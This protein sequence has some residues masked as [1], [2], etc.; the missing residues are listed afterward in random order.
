MISA[1][2]TVVWIV[3]VAVPFL[4]DLSATQ[5]LKL[6]WRVWGKV[7][8]R[9]PCTLAQAGQPLSVAWVSLQ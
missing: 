5:V 2:A 1:T 7:A 3:I 8:L 4:F 9:L 6:I